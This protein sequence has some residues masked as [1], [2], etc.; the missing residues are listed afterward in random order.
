MARTIP[1]GARAL[2]AYIQ[3]FYAGRRVRLIYG[4]MRDKAVDEITGIL[5]PLADQVIVTAPQQAR[6]VDPG[7]DSGARRPPQRPHRAES[8]RG[9]GDGALRSG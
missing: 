9:P 1:P 3:R 4:A 8:C 7:N 2:A 5:F 6:A